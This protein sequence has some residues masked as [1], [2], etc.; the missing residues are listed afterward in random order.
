MST[1]Y[2]ASTTVQVAIENP[3]SGL[4]PDFT[5]FGAEF[6]TWWQKLFVALWALLLICAGGALLISFLQMRKATSNNIPGQADEAK[7]HAIWAGG[8]VVCLAGFGVL[9]G[10]ILAVAG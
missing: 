9:M 10:A 5:V 6:T 8:A 7:S 1:L 4:V 3:F 2:L